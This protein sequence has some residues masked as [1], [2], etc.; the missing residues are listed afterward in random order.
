[1]Q[2]IEIE[3]TLN[4]SPLPASA[5]QELIDFYEF[6]LEKYAKNQPKTIQKKHRSALSQRI[7]TAQ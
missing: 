3:N 4:L 1:M 7:S 5:Q 6:L 2:A